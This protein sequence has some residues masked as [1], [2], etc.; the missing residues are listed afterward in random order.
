VS[1]GSMKAALNT[2]I[3][4][5]SSKAGAFLGGMLLLPMIAFAQVGMHVPATRQ[6]DG[7]RVWVASWAAAAQPYGVQ[8][9]M[10]KLPPIPAG[11][12]DHQT[13]RVRLTA[14][15]AGERL[16]FR[17][18]NVFGSK[19][20]HI[21][22]A[23]VARSS[24]GFAIQEDTAQVLRFKGK[25]QVSIAPGAQVWSDP[26][27]F[28]AQP[29]DDVSV[30]F[31]LDSASVY[32]TVYN[33]TEEKVWSAAGNGTLK[34]AMPGTVRMSLGHILTGMDVGRAEPV[35]VVVAFGDSISVG[36]QDPLAARLR[37]EAGTRSEAALIKA[38]IA[39][40]RLL[41]PWIGPKGIERFRRDVLD[42]SGVSHVVVLLGIN[43][44]GFSMSDRWLPTPGLPSAAQLS[45]GLQKLILQAHAKGVKVILGT[46]T[47]FKGSS[48]WDA[49][50]ESRR[51]ALNAW[52]R[53]QTDVAAVADF[54]L[55]LREPSD[56]SRL[57]AIF[58]S[59]DHLHPSPAGA[60]AMVQRISL[61]E[62]SRLARK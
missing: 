22:A 3:R 10:A 30:S 28:E 56:P 58:D 38:G 43:D 44:I 60:L 8:P 31:Y 35:R 50:K 36:Y 29:G 51:Q 33:L 54:D 19:A 20:L 37:A 45:V 14:S 52:I 11:L 13:L 47:P 1:R 23:S 41:T 9:P 12:L 59:G 46:L 27:D 42:Q 16:R 4:S 49:E 15:V 6:D 48:Y 26:V 5:I 53:G 40:N 17:F 21:A 62:P 32:A 25:P 57:R 24:E 7:H 55:A 61:D 34:S 18:S 2:L 39:G